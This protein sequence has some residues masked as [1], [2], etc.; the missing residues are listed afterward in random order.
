MKPSF[1][2]R[3]SLPLLLIAALFPVR[4]AQAQSQSDWKAQDV[5]I[6][7]DSKARVLW[8]NRGG[9]TTLW[10]VTT[11][12]D[13]EAGYNKPL[14]SGWTAKAVAVGGDALARLMSTNTD[15]RMT[16]EVVGG[17]GKLLA[18]H[19]YG[20][21]AGWTA[22]DLTCGRDN[23]TR[24]LWRKND[25]QVSLW[26]VGNTDALPLQSSVHHGPYPGWTA[27]NISVDSLGKAR[28][29]WLN[30]DGRL[31]F[32]V[33]TPD[34]KLESSIDHGPFAGWTPFDLAT[35][36]KSG[37]DN[38]SRLAWKNTS[39]QLSLWIADAK[40]NRQSTIEHGPYP[41]YDARAITL[42][43]SGRMR[44][45]WNEKSG[46]ADL[47]TTT[48]AGS[49]ASFGS[50]NYA[51]TNF[52]AKRQTNSSG[53]T[54]GV[55]LSWTA[56]AHASSYRIIRTRSGNG[57]FLTFTST[58]PSFTDS[59]IEAGVTYYYR[60]T[61]LTRAVESASA[62]ASVDIPAKA[63]GGNVNLAVE[64][65]PSGDGASSTNY[66]G[67]FTATDGTGTKQVEGTVTTCDLVATRPAPYYPGHLGQVRIKLS[68]AKPIQAGTQFVIG[69]D[70]AS[71]GTYDYA[72]LSSY[73]SFASAV[74]SRTGTITVTAVTDNSISLRLTDV[75]MKGPAGQVTP[76]G[77]GDTATGAFFFNGTFV[78]TNLKAPEAPPSPFVGYYSGPIK[79]T[80]TTSTEYSVAFSIA[81]DGSISGVCRYRNQQGYPLT[82]T[83]DASG[84]VTMK[85]Q[86][87]NNFAFQGT[88]SGVYNTRTI[89]G[90]VTPAV[91]TSSTFEAH[92][93]TAPATGTGQVSTST[94]SAT[95]G[96]GTHTVN[97]DA[98]F[99]HSYSLSASKA[100]GPTSY[101]RELKVLLTKTSTYPAVGDRF[102]IGNGAD[103][104]TVSISVRQT[105]S[106]NYYE[107]ESSTTNPNAGAATPVV[108]IVAVSDD[109]ISLR[110]SDVYMAPAPG[111][112]PVMGGS[113]NVGSPFVLS[114]TFSANNLITTYVTS[115][116]PTNTPDPTATP[117]PVPV[118][119]AALDVQFSDVSPDTN[120]ITTPLSVAHEASG[121]YNQQADEQ[122]SYVYAKV[123]QGGSKQDASGF[124]GGTAD[125]PARAIDVTLVLK[126]PGNGQV[127]ALYQGQKFPIGNNSAD[128]ATSG[129]DY[130]GVG[131]AEARGS[132]PN[133]QAPYYSNTPVAAGRSFVVVEKIDSKNITFRLQNAVMGYGY[134]AGRTQFTLN[135]TFTIPNFGS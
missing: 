88:F 113:G 43:T 57:E 18:S 58:R 42:D 29:A 56:S 64:P 82:G 123:R 21:N 76:Y 37:G 106:M 119:G 53:A 34:L 114:G 124:Y 7:P 95:N 72:G 66:Q 52:V 96:T 125:N 40:G 61:A 55:A 93:G 49:L 100:D 46:G 54:S 86:G 134:S 10:T 8:T 118:A 111:S 80:S 91:V 19:T 89:S 65:A 98:P 68:S 129:R 1:L 63:T 47:W 110:F 104:G 131:Y 73:H 69:R 12:G 30:S 32:W 31:S 107:E 11:A 25:G 97:T 121:A 23:I 126:N 133:S 13:I 116:T 74:G 9:N 48:V 44:V 130:A 59:T 26:K 4:P 22:V 51:P 35:N 120:A 128:D 103:P 5:A 36:S 83:V 50:Y 79:D 77:D 75:Y 101:P 70:D 20:P 99:T 94:L 2:A 81:S 105:Q 92:E 62:V 6:G 15:G 109:S 115:P 78:A 90:S 45:L 127:A 38:S 33:T 132:G 39:G 112:A 135:G 60:L 3:L 27:Q 85:E 87:G 71:V 14:G 24:V 16:L 84:N 41:N 108:E 122:Y 17:G 28:L 102:A 67:P 117:A